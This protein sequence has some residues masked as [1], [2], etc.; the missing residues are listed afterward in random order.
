MK[1]HILVKHK[2]CY[3]E[4]F[5]L[6]ESLHAM[7][8]T[9]HMILHGNKAEVHILKSPTIL[10][11]QTSHSVWIG[12]GNNGIKKHFQ[13]FVVSRQLHTSVHCS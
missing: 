1:K 3:V 6:S 13:V 2:M 9:L 4:T 12:L 10:F 11:F 5:D 8:N 7:L